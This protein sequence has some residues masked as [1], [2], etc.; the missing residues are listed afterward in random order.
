MTKIYVTK[1]A[2]TSGVFSIDAEIKPGGKSAT[3]RD[4]MNH[5]WF[6][7]GKE[8]WLTPEEAI[9]DCEY[10]RKSKLLSLEKQKHKIENLNFNLIKDNL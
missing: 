6:V 3:F 9:A 4:E 10:R 1:Y 5:R 8:F 2:L 7:Y